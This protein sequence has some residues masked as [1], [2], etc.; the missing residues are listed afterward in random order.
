M[1]G[2]FAQKHGIRVSVGGVDLWAESIPCNRNV[3]QLVCSNEHHRTSQVV[4]TGSVTRVHCTCCLFC[5]SVL[6]YSVHV[7]WL[8]CDT[9]AFVSK[10]VAEMVPNKVTPHGDT[11]EA[12]LWWAMHG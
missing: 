4:R 12:G 7:P 1:G 10:L 3:H 8:V 11:S 2:N 5:L 6:S 9:E